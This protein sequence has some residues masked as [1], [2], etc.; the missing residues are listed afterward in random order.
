MERQGAQRGE[1]IAGLR[2]PLPAPALL[3][4]GHTAIIVLL[5]TGAHTLISP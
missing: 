5:A 3:P 1:R 2:A 4:A